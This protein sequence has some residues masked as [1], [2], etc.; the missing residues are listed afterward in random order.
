MK[1]KLTLLLALMIAVISLTLASCA[2]TDDGQMQDTVPNEDTQE[3]TPVSESSLPP[4]NHDSTNGY[5]PAETMILRAEYIGM[6][7]SNSIEVYDL[8]NGLVQAVRLTDQIKAFLEE[9]DLE[10]GSI[11]TA[12]YYIDENDAVIIESLETGIDESVELEAIYVGQMDSGSIEARNTG[13]ESVC[14]YRFSYSLKNSFD[15]LELCEGETIKI[16]YYTNENGSRIILDLKTNSERISLIYSGQIDSNSIECKYPEDLSF[17]AFRLSDEVKENFAN[18]N[19][20][21]GETIEIL[22]YI[23]E[24]GQYVIKDIVE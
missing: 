12:Q 19:L 22:Y 14:A 18:Y 7:D 11:V 5:E 8:D 4:E 21:E 10:I 17:R 20:K 16:I 9:N 23:D 13:D 6:I 24:N 1:T 3:N 15:D 2:K